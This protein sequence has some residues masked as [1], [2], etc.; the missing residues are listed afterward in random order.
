MCRGLTR[1]TKVRTERGVKKDIRQSLTIF[2]YCSVI[3]GH[4]YEGYKWGHFR[5]QM[6]LGTRII[7]PGRKGEG[8]RA[9]WSV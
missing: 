4:T 9:M 6:T 5:A 1:G 3:S 2:A 7:K 8:T